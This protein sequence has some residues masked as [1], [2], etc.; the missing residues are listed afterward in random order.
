MNP[1]ILLAQEVEESLFATWGWLAAAVLLAALFAW[2]LAR[3]RGGRVLAVLVAMLAGLVAVVALAVSGPVRSTLADTASRFWAAAAPA[4]S[5]PFTWGILLGAIGLLL[6]LPQ[7]TQTARRIGAV[8]GIVSLGLLAAAFSLRLPLGERVLFWLLALLTLGSAA[9]TISMR[10]AVY[11]A[12]WFALSLFGTA[13][14]FLFQGA[15]FLGVATIVVYAG[16]IVVTLLFMIMLA[17]PT[18]HAVYDRL[19]WGWF[20]KLFSVLTAAAM[21][22]VLSILLF[23]SP[24]KPMRW[25]VAQAL[26]DLRDDNK[27]RLLEDDQLVDASLADNHTLVVQLRGNVPAEHVEQ[28]KEQ[29]PA[30]V[31]AVDPELNVSGVDLNFLEARDDVL[32]QQHMAHLGTELFSRHLVSVEAAGTVL[33]AALVGAVAIVSHGSRRRDAEEDGAV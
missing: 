4:A 10:S 13:A 21:V 23:G 27:L 32:H 11:A 18:G 5:K 19:S 33:L 7:G 28:L 31:N 26:P 17:Q 30:A 12:I 2:W 15:Q 25:K 20:P 6:I 22:I 29:L 16:A 14:L 1:G 9:A 3:S 24:A 8:L